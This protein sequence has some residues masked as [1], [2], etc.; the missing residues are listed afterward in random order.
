MGPIFIKKSFSRLKLLGITLS[1]MKQVK[2]LPVVYMT[3][4]EKELLSCNFRKGDTE[5]FV[6]YGLNLKGIVFSCI[7]IENSSEGKIKMSFRSQGDFSVNYFAKTYFNGGG[8]QNAS[9]GMSLESLENT[10]IKFKNAIY[11]ISDQF[12]KSG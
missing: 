5:G 4:N 6:N 9:G 3:L 10:V 11:E 2:G 12:F 8:H 7:M 1:N